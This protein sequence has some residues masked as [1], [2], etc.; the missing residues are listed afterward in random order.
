LAAPPQKDQETS[1]QDFPMASEV[2]T[3]IDSK[4]QE[5][6][7]LMQVTLGQHP[8]DLVIMGGTI[9]DVNV[10]QL[11]RADIAIRGSRIA[12]VGDVEHTIGPETQQVDASNRFIAPGLIDAHM[13]VETAMVTAHA[14][15]YAVLPRGTT[16][17]VAE[18]HD[19]ADVFGL[20]G[21]ELLRREIQHLPLRLY[22]MAPNPVPLSGPNLG[23]TLGHIGPSEVA[24]MMQWPEVLGLGKIA[25][26][27]VLA[28]D[29]HQVA[30]LAIAH[31]FAKPLGGRSDY[32]R[33]KEIQ[34]MVAAGIS[35]DYSARTVEHM[36]EWLQA[37]LK[38]IVSEGST[39][40]HATL[41]AELIQK[42]DIDPR[43]C[44]LCTY[45]RFAD[46]VRQKGF[47]D[48]AVRV[49]IQNGVDPVVAI[50]TATLNTAEHFGIAA[51]LGSIAPG[52][53]ADL[54]IIGD[55][56]AFEVS[57]VYVSGRRVA[58][59]GQLLDPPAAYKYPSWAKRTVTLPADF[60]ASSLKYPA[61]IDE[62][63][64]TVRAIGLIPNVSA[65]D[66][67]RELQVPLHVADGQILA[68][69]RRD[70]LKLVAVE[71]FGQSGSIGRGFIRGLGFQHG[72]IA[73][74]IA[75]DYHCVIAAGVTDQDI[76]FAVRTLD[77]MGG[78]FVIVSDGQ[79]LASIQL[80][81]GGLIT[82]RS[83]DEVADETVKMEET[84]HQLGYS[85]PLPEML[86]NALS[87]LSL[88][89]GRELRLSDKGYI[90]HAAETGKLDI[91]PLIVQE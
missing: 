39:V 19:L 87:F 85:L 8:S 34:A 66:Q 88:P 36:L 59:R 44:L 47:I 33:G 15:A 46:D 13:H 26:R 71:R 7:D 17:L 76:A 18:P 38:V 9:V 80:E 45:D 29:A 54:L 41:L 70:V 64:L 81:I 31:A 25:P 57:S 10:R 14:L 28:R 42:H 55:L 37:G 3:Q 69:P 68:D 35:D 74:T 84:A 56:P 77:T 79:V 82:E 83:L 65:H 50:Q 62:G 52:K 1:S 43:H 63:S 6:V 16:V 67:T 20:Q 12:I 40:A 58:E 32:L 5:R 2:P 11:R 4:Y 86:H 75:H 72:A 78:G 73:G 30:K 23:S 21:V 89:L 61:P 24:T 90:G 49:L 22:I 91:V 51:D 53:L 60:A 48:E 27:S